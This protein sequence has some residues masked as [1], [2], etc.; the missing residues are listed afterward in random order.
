MKTLRPLS[1]M[2]PMRATM[3]DAESIISLISKT[4]ADLLLSTSL[5]SDS[6]DKFQEVPSFI[7]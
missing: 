2:S 6:P 3:L 7:G 1:K 5:L 4:V